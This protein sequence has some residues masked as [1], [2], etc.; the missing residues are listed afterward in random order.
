VLVAVGDVADRL[1]EAVKVG[2]GSEEGSELTP[3]I[4]DS[5]RK[6]VK[7]YI[8]L[9]EREPGSSSTAGSRPVKRASS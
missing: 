7:D 9:G 1:V 5:H 2:P 3:V 6:K 8:D 4:R